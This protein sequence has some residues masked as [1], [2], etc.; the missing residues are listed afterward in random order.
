MSKCFIPFKSCISDPVYYVAEGSVVTITIKRE[1]DASQSES[2]KYK[3]LDGSALVGD[4]N[5][6]TN[7]DAVFGVGQTE[8]SFL[9]TINED[10]LPEGNETFYIEIF[11]I[12]GKYFISQLILSFMFFCCCF[13][14]L[15]LS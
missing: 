8:V 4:Y 5:K 13:F 15:L 6:L 1:G 10:D 11:Q 2:V 14:F 3:T 7:Q 12:M 9:V